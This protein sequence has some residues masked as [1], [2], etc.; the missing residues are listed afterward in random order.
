MLLI[1]TRLVRVGIIWHPAALTNVILGVDELLF[2]N[3]Q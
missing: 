3:E 1:L 2:F